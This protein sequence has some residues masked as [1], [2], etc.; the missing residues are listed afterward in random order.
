[1]TQLN[2]EKQVNYVTKF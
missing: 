1:M 2:C